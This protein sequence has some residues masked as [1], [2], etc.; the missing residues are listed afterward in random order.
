MYGPSNPRVILFAWV[1]HLI[2]LSIHSIATIR[3]AKIYTGAPSQGSSA[4]MRHH[5]FRP[6]RVRGHDLLRAV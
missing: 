2:L 3:M 5:R 4:G 6:A 1:G